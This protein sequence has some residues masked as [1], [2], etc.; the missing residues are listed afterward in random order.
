[1]RTIARRH[2]LVLLALAAVGCGGKY[3]PVAV[4][5]TVTL[6]GQ[7]VEGAMVS[8]LPE[9]GTGRAATGMTDPDGTFQLTTFQE[10]DGA[11]PG[12][13]RVIVTR[14]DA[15]PEPP[16]PLRPGNAQK[17]RE[18]YRQVMAHR[19]KRSSLPAVYGDE[20]KT[21]FA[22]TVPT[23]EKVVLALQGKPGT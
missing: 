16:E 15:I 17:V 23:R 6:D 2:G 4:E 20:T 19:D 1:M 14:T 22:I 21:P 13:Y 9:N 8:F 5:G 12:T 11:L 3:T 7:P 10:G 18:H